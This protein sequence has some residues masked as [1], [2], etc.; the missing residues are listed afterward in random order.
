MILLNIQV[1]DEQIVQNTPKRE[2]SLFLKYDGNAST[3]FSVFFST[4]VL[5]Y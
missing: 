2:L 3:V 5:A 4:I 1:L